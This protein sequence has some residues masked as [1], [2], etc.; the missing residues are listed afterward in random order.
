VTPHLVNPFAGALMSI[1]GAVI[2]SA[3]VILTAVF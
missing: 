1:I 3:C 2:V